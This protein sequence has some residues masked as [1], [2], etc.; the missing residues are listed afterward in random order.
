MR[1]ESP[2]LPAT[3]VSRRSNFLSSRRAPTRMASIRRRSL[4]AGLAR[5]YRPAFGG[6]PARSAGRR[7]DRRPRW[8]APP[9][10]PV[11]APACRY[12][13][14]RHAPDDPLPRQLLRRLR[15]GRPLRPLHGRAR[16]RPA[17]PAWSTAPWPT[18]RATP[19][20]P[21]PSTAR[22]TPASTSATRPP[23]A[24][25]V[26]RPPRQRLPLA[27]RPGQ[28]S[29]RAARRQQFWDPHGPLLHRLHRPH[30]ARAV[31]LGGARPRGAGPLGRG[32]RRRP[33]PLRRRGG[34][35]WRSRRCAS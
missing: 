34:P 20:R 5:R 13:A 25:L 16:G 7:G 21:T 23:R 24:P 35:R 6:A 19:S 10:P 33:L 27:G 28:P 15:L 30:P 12:A 2:C 8:G 31:R 32:H 29:R 22:S 11:R 4:L 9:R 18:S 17:R 26:V 3:R 1:R 14:R